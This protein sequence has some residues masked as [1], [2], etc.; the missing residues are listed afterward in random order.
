M[1]TRRGIRR[2][3]E[4]IDA[5]RVVV[6]PLGRRAGI[7]VVLVEVWRELAQEEGLELAPID[8]VRAVGVDG[9]PSGAGR[10]AQ[11]W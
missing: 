4:A 8:T 6:E 5:V 11:G 9:L 1:L 3:P 2:V 10:P 7:S